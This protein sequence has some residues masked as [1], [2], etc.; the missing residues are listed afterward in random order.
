MKKIVVILIALMSMNIQMHAGKE[1]I[2]G[3]VYY[4]NKDNMEA[5]IIGVDGAGISSQLIIPSKVSDKKGKTPC[6]CIL[7][8]AKIRRYSCWGQN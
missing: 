4:V 7:Q 2:G 6:V 5:S 3:L 8:K 1:K